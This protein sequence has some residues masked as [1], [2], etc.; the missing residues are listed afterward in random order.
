MSGMIV[1]FAF[2]AL[3]SILS[4][5]KSFLLGLGCFLC[6]LLFLHQKKNY[7]HYQLLWIVFVFV[8]YFLVGYVTEHHTTTV[9]NGM[10]KQFVVK[11]TEPWRVDGG[12]MQTVAMLPNQKERLLLK[13]RLS[14]EQEKKYYSNATTY[15]QLCK[16][17]GQL[18]RPSP[19]RNPHA[20]HYEQYLR[21]SNIHWIFVLDS[22]N[23]SECQS[24][25]TTPISQLAKLRQ[26]GLKHIENQFPER[27]QPIVA[28]LLFGERALFDEQLL[29]NYRRLGVIHLLAISGLH[30]GLLVGM[31][32]YVALRLGM[33][34]ERTIKIILLLLP[35]Y[36]LLTGA[37]P[38]VVRAV[39]MISCLLVSHLLRRIKIKPLDSISFA[40]L[41][42]L[43]FRP[44]LLFHPGFQLSF[45]V[46]F[47]LILSAP[48]ILKRYTQRITQ[49]LVVSLI[50]Q[51]SS[52]P[53]LLL[54]FYEFSIIAAVMNVLYV[55]VFS[56]FI[57]PLSMITFLLSLIFPLIVPPLYVILS[58][59]IYILDTLTNLFSGFPIATLT[60]GKPSLLIFIFYFIIVGYFFY[61]WERNSPLKRQLRYFFILVLTCMLHWVGNVYSPYGQV[62]FIDVGQGDSIFIQLPFRHGNYL[63]DTGGMMSF[64]KEDWQESRKVFD[65]G[66]DIVVPFLKSIGVTKIDKLIV[67]HGDVDHMGGTFSLL[68]ELTVAE[69]LL[70]KVVERSELEEQLLESARRGNIPVRFV[71]AGEK[72]KSGG[73][74]FQ[75]LSPLKEN[76][77][78]NKNDTSIVLYCKMGSL[79]WLFTG[80]LE[81]TG[82]QLLLKSYPNIQADVLKVGHH[83]SKTSS[84]E[85]FLEQLGVKIAI[86]SAGNS[87]R[88]GHPH[89]EVLTRLTEKNATIFRT[90]LHGAIRYAYFNKR[91]GT[92][93][94]MIP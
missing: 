14:T 91:A 52:L 68:E 85:P 74:L 32:Y 9:L 19:A 37:A 71:S 93:S 44:S 33:T 92:F 3:L 73:S 26:M 79:S 86:I 23:T 63:I 83:G 11:I 89:Q 29:E 27:I 87:N 81:E 75:V 41:I 47:S 43:L 1:F 70:P 50:A 38:S 65:T 39:L 84:S 80:D 64:M 28:A 53:I 24:L 42:C 56:L 36:V 69:I 18:V 49:L 15:P 67:T 21:S 8:A 57:L 16:V 2:A 61:Q 10:E 45:L 51:I 94:Y 25:Q 4:T 62:T 82:E 40:F 6:F 34:K 58:V 46:S 72:W 90:D 12:R 17:S 77:H 35:A 66:S 59:A 76:P 78:S 55:P 13:Y 7:K 22:F 88:Y 48:V 54:H 20:F 60:L 30:V 31:L 5:T